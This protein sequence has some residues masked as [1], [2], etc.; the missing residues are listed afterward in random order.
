L[1]AEKIKQSLLAKA[2]RGELVEQDPRDEPASVLL[3]RIRTER[4]K[5]KQVTSGKSKNKYQ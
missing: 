2:F 1:K 4:E 3:E 5:T